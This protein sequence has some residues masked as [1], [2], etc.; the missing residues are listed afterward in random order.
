MECAN[1]ERVKPGR[2]MG[3]SLAARVAF[4]PLLLRDAAPGDLDPYRPQ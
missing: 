3:H 4:R 2:P 1:R